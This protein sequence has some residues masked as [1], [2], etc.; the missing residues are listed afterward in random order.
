MA[1]LSGRRRPLRALRHGVARA[2]IRALVAA[3]R[4]IAFAP[5]E[6]PAYIQFALIGEVASEH[7]PEA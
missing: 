3:A 5:N 7:S 6:S 1:G 4:R 2:P